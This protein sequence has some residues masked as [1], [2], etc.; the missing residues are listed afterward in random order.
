MRITRPMPRTWGAYEPV[1]FV[2]DGAATRPVGMGMVALAP[3]DATVSGPL[4]QGMDP[5]NPSTWV[6]QWNPQPGMIGYLNFDGAAL[7]ARTPTGGVF[8]GS[9]RRGA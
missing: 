7:Q 9:Q 3:L 4:Y 6:R 5:S 2:S 8:R 1:P